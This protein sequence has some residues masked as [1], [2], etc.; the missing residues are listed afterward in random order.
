M[1][2]AAGPGSFTGVRIGM[3][4][5]EGLAWSLGVPVAPVSTLEAMAWMFEG[6][7]GT[8]CCCMDARRQQVYRAVFELQG[9]RPERLLE[10]DAVSIAQLEEELTSLSGE[11]ILVGDGARLCYNSLKGHMENIRTAPEHLLYQTA[12]GVAR[13]ALAHEELFAPAE[14]AR[15]S[16]HRLSQAERERLARLEKGDT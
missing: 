9:G 15:I 10:D 1:A 16:Y 4:A 2:A 14:E 8:V 13:C 7:S 5:A 6:F 12:W 11:I 3:A